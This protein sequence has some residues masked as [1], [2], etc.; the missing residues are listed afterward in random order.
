MLSE[1]EYTFL[2]N[3]KRLV[4][5]WNTVAVL[6]FVFLVAVFLWMFFTFPYLINPLYV[7]E[8]I[9]ANAMEDST[10]ITASILL[11]VLVIC[12]FALVAMF[13]LFGFSILSKE[14]R[15]LTIYRKITES[16]SKTMTVRW[17]T[18]RCT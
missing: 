7:T 1:N 2:K 10:M 11:P 9:Q 14:K 3:R 4:A 5:T 8:A 6:M 12:L 16:S 17:L 18:V 15:Y 13:I